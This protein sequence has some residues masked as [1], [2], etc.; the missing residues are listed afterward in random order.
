MASRFMCL[1]LLAAS[2][3]VG[4]V[5]DQTVV[6]GRYCVD[7]TFC[8]ARCFGDPAVFEVCPTRHDG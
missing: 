6:D 5:V 8:P 2:E 3:F 7:Q 1:R 4:D